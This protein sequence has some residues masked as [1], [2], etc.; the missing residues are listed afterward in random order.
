M[1]GHLN[2]AG[3]LS[4]WQSDI[5]Q[6]N[7]L[8]GHSGT[9]G[10]R[11]QHLIWCHSQLCT[12]GRFVVGSSIDINMA[13]LQELPSEVLLQPHVPVDPIIVRTYWQHPEFKSRT[14]H[15]WHLGWQSSLN[16]IRI[17]RT[18]CFW[19]L[20]MNP[21]WS[22]A[23]EKHVIY[24]DSKEEMVKANESLTECEYYFGSVQ[25]YKV[26]GSFHTALA[27]SSSHWKCVGLVY[28][29]VLWIF[30]KKR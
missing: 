2:S 28:G 23:L 10:V 17:D 9:L 26:L 15:K 8:T 13:E 29:S 19:G 18:L 6:P 20:K 1:A 27:C 21:Q 30:K 24:T 11:F 16:I 4:Y 3:L 25:V 5:T 22:S 7:H 14:A 12:R